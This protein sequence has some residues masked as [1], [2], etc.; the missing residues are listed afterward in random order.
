MGSQRV[1]HNWAT[2]PN[3]PNICEFISGLSIVFH[4]SVFI[5]IPCWWPQLC[6]VVW[7]EV[8]RHYCSYCIFHTSW[9]SQVVL[10]VKN[11]PANAGDVRGTSSIPG[12]GRPL[13]GEHGNPLEHSC[14]EN[15]T[16]RGVWKATVHRV[17]QCQTWL[18]WR[19]MHAHTL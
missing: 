11:P 13:R 5:L 3:W 2:E 9:A 12:L 17:A 6:N 10:V 19:S 8:W 16:D 4:W 14:L 15:S 18:K 7:N 1:R